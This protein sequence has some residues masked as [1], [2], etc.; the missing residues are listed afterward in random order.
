MAARQPGVARHP[1]DAAAAAALTAEAAAQADPAA[2][3]RTRLLAVCCCARWRGDGAAEAMVGRDDRR[4]EPE[5]R[6]SQRP[7]ARAPW[8]WSTRRCCEACGNPIRSSACPSG[9]LSRADRRSRS[10]IRAHDPCHPRRRISRLQSAAPSPPLYSSAPALTRIRAPDLPVGHFGRK[11]EAAANARKY[12]ARR[13]WRTKRRWRRW[14]G[15]GCKSTVRSIATRGRRLAFALAV[16]RRAPRHS[17]A[18]RVCRALLFPPDGSCA[19]SGC[20]R[21]RPMRRA[22]GLSFLSRDAIITRAERALHPSAHAV[23]SCGRHRL[24]AG[25]RLPTLLSDFNHGG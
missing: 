5:N 9:R 19:A 10:K 7:R 11:G 17:E 18:R 14:R 13:R 1:A 6:R 12:S 3:R 8:R 21:G 24:T 2:G 22:P 20:S 16:A 23:H 4:A 15:R 25:G